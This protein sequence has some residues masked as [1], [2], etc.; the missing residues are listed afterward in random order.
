MH[1]DQFL[2]IRYYNFKP[3]INQLLIGP[4]T[5]RQEVTRRSDAFHDPCRLISACFL[6]LRYNVLIHA[7]N[8]GYLSRRG[9]AELTEL[10]EVLEDLPFAATSSGCFQLPQPHPSCPATLVALSKSA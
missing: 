10:E 1:P 4:A 8:I 9:E 6:W 5:L 7:E 2:S 3:K